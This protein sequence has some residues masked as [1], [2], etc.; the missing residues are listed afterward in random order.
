MAKHE[1]ISP[2]VTRKKVKQSEALLVCAYE[3]DKK[4]R[5]MRLEG[6]ISYNEFKKKLSSMPKDQEIIFYCESAQ[7]EHASERAEEYANKGFENVKVLGNG[8][9]AWRKAG[10]RI[11]EET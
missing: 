9:K 4:F 5:N 2:E 6:A 1:R 7:E 8:L 10:Y 11:E 3:E